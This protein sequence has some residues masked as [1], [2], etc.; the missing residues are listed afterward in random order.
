MPEQVEARLREEL[1]A[2]P[3]AGFSSPW[4]LGYADFVPQS[5]GSDDCHYDVPSEGNGGYV[6]AD[7]PGGVCCLVAGVHLPE[8]A[9]VS[10]IF[11][12]LRDASADDVTLS[13]RR[14]RIDDESTS[15]AM[16]STT[17]SGTGAGVRLFSDVSITEGV[18]D[19]RS[20]SYFVSTDTCL[21]QGLDLRFVGA[22]VF[23]TEGS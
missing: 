12:F 16:G 9:T 3:E 22:L 6:A 17:T 1:Q 14:K 7:S 11:F 8:G 20:Y 15:T 2:S 21:D 10:S 23:F 4:N 18:I 13:L 19:N 5:V